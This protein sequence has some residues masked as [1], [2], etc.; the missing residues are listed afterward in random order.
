MQSYL[1]DYHRGVDLNNWNSLSADN[2]SIDVDEWK[3][4]HTDSVINGY[5]AL[6]MFAFVH[7][8][9]LLVGSPNMFICYVY[10]FFTLWT[11]LYGGNKDIDLSNYLILFNVGYIVQGDAAVW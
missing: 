4:Q 6:C 1:L 3:C 5:L 11:L 2:R 9:Y 10:M 8:S 7:M